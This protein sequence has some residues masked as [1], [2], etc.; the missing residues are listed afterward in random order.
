[1]SGGTAALLRR[2]W[3]GAYH[4]LQRAILPR[5]NKISYRKI[6]FQ[7]RCRRCNQATF[8]Y[9]RWPGCDSAV[10]VKWEPK[11]ALRGASRR[12][13]PQS[14]EVTVVCTQRL[15]VHPGTTACTCRSSASSRSWRRA[16]P[17]LV[18]CLSSICQICCLSNR[19]KGYVAMSQRQRRSLAPTGGLT[20]GLACL[21][22]HQRG[23]PMLWRTN[24][25]A[26]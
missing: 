14:L 18:Q 4:C 5:D 2:A 1:M 7:K 13:H 11:N 25:G 10:C 6:D 8:V 15:A 17:G 26:A 21:G 9:R 22:V 20:K 24:T 19:C 23:R 16:V 12:S 3:I